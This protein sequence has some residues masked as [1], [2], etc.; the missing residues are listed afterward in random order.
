MKWLVKC[1]KLFDIPVKVFPFSLFFF[2]IVLF[3]G[4][5][6]ISSDLLSLLSLHLVLKEKKI[7]SQGLKFCVPFLGLSHCWKAT[8]HFTF[9]PSKKHLRDRNHSFK[10]VLSYQHSL[11]SF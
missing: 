3:L 10:P 5:S 9:F 8:F 11:R 1:N 6:A 4:L 7:I 2:F